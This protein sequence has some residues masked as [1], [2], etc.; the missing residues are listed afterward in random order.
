[1]LANLLRGPPPGVDLFTLLTVRTE[2]SPALLKMIEELGLGYPDILPLLP[3]SPASYRDV[4]LEP[5]RV[6]ARSGRRV[7][8]TALLAERLTSDAVGADALP[9]LAFT[10][11]HLY[12]EFGAGGT[13]DV[14]QYEQI[15]GIAGTIQLALKHAL[16]K[17]GADPVIPAT[18]EAQHAALRAAFIP[19]LAR[20]NPDTGAAMRR[21]ARVADLPD[22]GRAM[23]K[24]LVEARL[25]VADQRSGE[26]VVEIAHESLLRQ[27]P[28]LQEWLAADREDLTLVDGVEQSA[29]QWAEHGK[30]KDWLVHGGTR[31]RTAERVSRRADF[32][33]RLGE[34]GL[35]YL[36]ACRVRQRRRRFRAGA[37]VF[38]LAA[39]VAL[40]G[41]TWRFQRDLK[42]YAYWF[43]HVRGHVLSTD[44]ALALSGDES[45]QDC[46]D[47]PPMVVVPAGKF[48][49][50]SPPGQGDRTGREYHQHAVTIAA[51]FAVS[52]FEVTFAEWDVCATYGPCAPEIAAKWG[53][54][55]QPVI[56]ITWED[57]KAYAA[58]LSSI[59]GRPYRLLTEAEYEYAARAG[60]QTAY[61][62]GD[63]IGVGNAQCGECDPQSDADGPAT[64]GSF[65]LNQFGLGDMLGNVYEWVE[66]CF[67]GDYD[68]A[69][70]DGSAWSSPGCPRRVVRGGSWLSRAFD[71]RSAARDWT[72]VG[73]RRDDLG[74]R[75]ART[76]RPPIGSA[77]SPDSDAPDKSQAL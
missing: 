37:L 34:R 45:F 41:T 76:L 8:I 48:E 10:L 39:V 59:T 18:R 46:A 26:Q 9:L 31:L 43:T 47:C 25:L 13:I 62:W 69:P 75:V 17:P 20:I 11:S 24:R 52:K 63:S 7:T 16:A 66:D 22:G 35:A 2:A 33:R 72:N 71:L 21:V 27:W 55:R 57:A 12:Q 15:G 50:G 54:G 51:P 56:N 23:V 6:L 29:G 65:P 77:H 36:A 3:V 19:W 44:K 14:E 28:E 42:Q 32:R 74:F 73:D 5:L 58:W 64:V 4:I 40:G 68:G 67:H 53:R 1:M 38:S 61:P 60:T 30:G 49:M 70:A